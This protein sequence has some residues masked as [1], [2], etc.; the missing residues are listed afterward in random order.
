M[1]LP[2]ATGRFACL[3]GAVLAA[4]CACSPQ[5]APAS[6]P[7]HVAAEPPVQLPATSP[8]QVVTAAAIAR[9]EQERVG[10]MERLHARGIV[11]LRTRDDSGERFEQGD[12]DVRWSRGRGLAVSLSKLGDRWVWLGADTTHWWVFDLKAAPTRLQTGALTSTKAGLAPAFPWLMGARPLCPAPGA[13]PMPVGAAWRVRVETP[14]G[15]LPAGGVVHAVF[16][17]PS[18]LPVAVELSLPGGVVWRSEFTEWMS[19]ETP[20]VAQ[21]AWP[22]LPR[23]VRATSEGDQ[24][25][26]V[27]RIALDSA[28]ADPAVIERSLLYDRAHLQ[29]RFA[30]EVVEHDE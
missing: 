9:A 24:R 25:W 28:G 23:R 21:G 27:V 22:R 5:P 19:V 15:T 18:L 29:E 16:Q 6:A 8:P 11:E 30:P 20:G 7:A 3:A 10:A 26:A 12:L 1:R 2:R 14:V 17:V 4:G 13:E